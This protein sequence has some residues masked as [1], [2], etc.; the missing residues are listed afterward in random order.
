MTGSV[1]AESTLEKSEFGSFRVFKSSGNSFLASVG[2]EWKHDEESW[3]FRR[4]ETIESP[5][6]REREGDCGMPGVNGKVFGLDRKH[7]PCQEIVGGFS[8]L[9]RVKR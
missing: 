6:F 3:A 5:L 4:H 8:D 2:N 7:N 1:H 9:N